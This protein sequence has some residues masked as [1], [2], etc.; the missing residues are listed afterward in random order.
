MTG[1]IKQILK[2]DEGE[3]IA[4]CD[5][6]STL[7]YC[8]KQSNDDQVAYKRVDFDGTTETFIFKKII[9]AGQKRDTQNISFI[10]NKPYFFYE[11]G[12][13]YN[14][15][16]KFT[17]QSPE[18]ILWTGTN[19]ENEWWGYGGCFSYKDEKIVAISVINSSQNFSTKLFDLATGKQINT[20]EG[21]YERT[22][23]PNSDSPI[24]LF[25]MCSQRRGLCLYDIKKNEIVYKRNIPNWY[26]TKYFDN[27][28]WLTTVEDSTN[29]YRYD[30]SGPIRIIKIGLDGKELENFTIT[31]NLPNLPIYSFQIATNQ[32]GALLAKHKT[33][34]YNFR[35]NQKLLELDIDLPEIFS[36]NEKILLATT[37]ELICID[38]EILEP[39][40]KLNIARTA[41]I[42]EFETNK[43][44]YLLNNVYDHKK[45][46]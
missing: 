10:N 15:S 36:N 40:W 13:T 1:E 33:I 37:S 18:G 17:V 3:G 24:I 46:M 12:G 38:E 34:L 20:V 41:Y 30:T 45:T 22:D 9:I 25:N 4:D 35:T 14:K 27:T 16:Y 39:V 42:E 8:P 21:C 44:I 5:R 11:T 43:N 2:L 7:L 32:V 23:F 31:P 29:Q 19:G 6:D 28:I 26:Y